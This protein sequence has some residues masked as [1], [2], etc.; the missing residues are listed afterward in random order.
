MYD[1]DENKTNGNLRVQNTLG[2]ETLGASMYEENPNQLYP[3]VHIVNN[4]MPINSNLSESLGNNLHVVY[5][6]GNVPSNFITNDHE[7][8]TSTSSNLLNTS[9]NGKAPNTSNKVLL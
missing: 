4:P 7:N 1:S 6:L 8:A 2:N 3:Q 9:V 5:T